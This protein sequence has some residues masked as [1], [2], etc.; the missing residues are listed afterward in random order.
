LLEFDPTL[1]TFRRDREHRLDVDLLVVDEMSMVDVVLM[2]QLLRAVP[3][4]ACVV[5]VGDVDQLP[6]VGPGAVLADLIG[7]RVMP[8]VRLTEVFR[9]AG[10]SWIVRGA[11]QVNQG[12]IPD[13]APHNGGD[14]YFVEANQSSAIVERIVTMV[15][16]R[17]PTRFGFDP[18]RDVQ[19]LS[20][21]NRSE[22][23]TQALNARLQEVL[24]PARGQVEIKRFDRLFRIGDK[25]L[26]TRNNYEKEVFNGDIGLVRAIDSDE[27]EMVID[28]EG[29]EVQYD[30]AELDELTLA[31]ALSIHR[32]QGSEYPAV[33]IPLHTQ[34]FM[35]LQRNLLYTAITRGKKL[36]VLV[37]SRKALEIAVQRQD[38]ARRYSGLRWRLHQLLD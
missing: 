33:V 10:Q 19:V 6:S 17:I 12:V 4:R 2:N 15:Q 8:V 36:V 14:F 29:R 32:A 28:F 24:N 23:G 35:M 5:L 13:T 9:Q 18:L 7:S 21:M 27:Q 1:G 31:Y 38:T 37:G 16:Q 3:D 22:L 25:V 30:F 26:Q 11:H 34:H 20:P